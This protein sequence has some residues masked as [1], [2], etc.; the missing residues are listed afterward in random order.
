MNLDEDMALLVEGS[1][2]VTEGKQ[3][4]HMIHAIRGS[5]NTQ[6]HKSKNYPEYKGLGG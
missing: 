5:K 4:L 1:D 6:L 2:K 3:L